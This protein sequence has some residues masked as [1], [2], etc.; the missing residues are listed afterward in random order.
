MTDIMERTFLTVFFGA[1]RR[2]GF[3]LIFIL[4]VAW[5]LGA[6]WH[7]K[8]TRVYSKCIQ[9]KY[10]SK[11]STSQLF[12]NVTTSVLLLNS[13]LKIRRIKICLYRFKNAER[14]CTNWYY[15]CS[16]YILC[17]THYHY[18]G[19]C[20]SEVSYDEICSDHLLCYLNSPST[21]L[22]SLHQKRN[23]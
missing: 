12:K 6:L 13:L 18:H 7:L 2:R 20:R 16:H 11:Y 22:R 17:Y 9:K 23:C 19:K 15:Q 21:R 10:S 14:S 1:I 8:F 3:G 5:L 4:L